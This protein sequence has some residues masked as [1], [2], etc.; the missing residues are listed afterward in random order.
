MALLT[1]EGYESEA[2]KSNHV[3]LGSG[4]SGTVPGRFGGLGRSGICWGY[5]MPSPI[6]TTI[7]VGAAIRFGSAVTTRHIVFAVSEGV[8]S[9]SVVHFAVTFEDGGHLSLRRGSTF[10]NITSG[11]TGVLTATKTVLLDVWSYVEMKLTV[12]DTVGQCIVL[13]NGVEHINFSGDTQSAGTGVINTVGIG[14]GFGTGT[15]GI[16]SDDVYILDTT[17]SAPYNDFL[18]DVKVEATVP[19]GNGNSSQL[20]GSDGN[21]T[22]NYLLVDEIPASGTDYVG[23]STV[24]EKD[25][26][27]FGNL[28]TSS[29]QVLAVQASALAFKSDA[30]TANMMMVERAASGTERDSVSTPLVASPGVWIT[31]GPQAADPDSATWTIASVNS[32]EFGVKVD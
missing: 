27:N 1:I 21:S 30:G 22:D 32:A 23:S 24:G 18:G 26:Y 17:G 6:A 20:V 15:G 16:A 4:G 25:T 7:V 2:L 9:G 10:S 13:V 31:T 29:G 8:S 5:L 19:V 11:G 3:N 12:S 14:G 28:A